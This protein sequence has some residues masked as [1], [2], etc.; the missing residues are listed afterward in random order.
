MGSST[1]KSGHP[2][3][4]DQVVQNYLLV[5]LDNNIDE[6]KDDCRNVFTQL[7]PILNSINTFTDSDQCIQFIEGIDDEKVHII[8]SG[9]LG[10]HIVPCIH[11]MSQVETIFIFCGNKKRHE[12]WAKEWAKIKGVYTEVVPICQAIR[13][14]IEQAAQNSPSIGL[15]KTSSSGVSFANRDHLD[16]SFMYTQILKEILLSIE[17]EEKHSKEFIHYCREAV[18]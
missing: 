9:L 1:S 15:A 6:T 7:R 12:E 11:D 8:T 17:F 4:N 2:N 16:P 18:R 5:W 14:A 13:Q 10:Q 3:A